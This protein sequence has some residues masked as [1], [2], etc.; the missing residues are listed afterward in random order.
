MANS[1]L[2]VVP[3]VDISNYTYELK[4]LC[5]HIHRDYDKILALW[6][7]ALRDGNIY[8]YDAE[9]SLIP[10]SQPGNEQC[11]LITG[12]LQLDHMMSVSFVVFVMKHS[13]SLMRKY[14]SCSWL[15]IVHE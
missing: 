6:I 2:W 7:L 9:W 3:D 1:I 8:N 5:T 11:W 12:I 13:Y 15:D 14:A 10:R 4:I